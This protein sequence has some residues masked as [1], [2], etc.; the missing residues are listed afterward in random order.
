[1]D[2]PAEKKPIPR[3]TIYEAGRRGDRVRVLVDEHRDRVEV[4]YRDVHGK[5][6]KRV[7]DNTRAGKAEARAWAETYH[8]ERRATPLN[9]VRPHITIAE[10]WDRYAASPAFTHLRPKTRLGYTKRYGRWRNY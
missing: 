5:P 2:K 6:R 10:L 9:A 4:L 3:K 8:E 7:Y 1:M